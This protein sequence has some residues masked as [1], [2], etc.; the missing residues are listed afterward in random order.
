MDKLNLAGKIVLTASQFAW[1]QAFNENLSHRMLIN[2][3]ELVD[4]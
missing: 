4:T 1:C 2:T 3:L